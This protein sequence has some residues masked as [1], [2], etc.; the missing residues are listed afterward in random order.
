MGVFLVEPLSPRTWY[1]RTWYA[2]YVRQ[3][4]KRCDST[5]DELANW[6]PPSVDE[7]WSFL[8]VQFANVFDRGGNQW[9]LESMAQFPRPHEPPYVPLSY[10]LQLSIAPPQRTLT[11][12]LRDFAYLTN[13]LVVTS[14]LSTGRYFAQTPVIPPDLSKASRSSPLLY[15]STHFAVYV[16]N[17]TYFNF[18]WGLTLEG[19]EL[20]KHPLGVT[21]PFSITPHIAPLPPLRESGQGINYYAA[22]LPSSNTLPSPYVAR[23]IRSREYYTS[24]PPECQKRTSSSPA[25]GSPLLTR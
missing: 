12:L 11:L 2:M 20:S 19:L 5:G 7:A 15:P 14:Y 8:T 1:S 4:E 17:N 3:V 22:I 10:P 24:F 25:Q 23:R 13:T 6:P 9:F 16:Q 18:G 21:P